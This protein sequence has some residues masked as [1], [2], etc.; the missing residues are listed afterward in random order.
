[1]RANCVVAV[2]ESSSLSSS[3]AVKHYKL[4]WQN[5]HFKR[6]SGAQRAFTLPSLVCQFVNDRKMVE[7][8]YQFSAFLKCVTHWQINS[9]VWCGPLYLLVAIHIYIYIIDMCC[10]LDSWM[11]SGTQKTKMTVALV[12]VA[13][14][15]STL[16]QSMWLAG[17]YQA[18]SGLLL[19]RRRVMYVNVV[20]CDMIRVA[21]SPSPHIEYIE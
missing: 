21:T 16:I 8:S 1:M 9:Y 14:Y 20:A 12:P 3:I 13:L 10:T 18:V 17:A 19:L 5:N 7:S 15:I 2:A 6:N 4:C 11:P